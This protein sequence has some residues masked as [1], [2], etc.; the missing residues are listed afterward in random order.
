MHVARAFNFFSFLSSLVFKG[1][2][3][4]NKLIPIWFKILFLL[5]QLKNKCLKLY[6]NLRG[7]LWHKLCC[8]TFFIQII[9][10]SETCICFN[11][12]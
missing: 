6:Q 4:G 10:C 11:D 7:C 3:E 8:N 9:S 2:K 5:C 1:F 12:E